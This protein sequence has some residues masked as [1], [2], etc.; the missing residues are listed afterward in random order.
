MPTSV[1]TKAQKKQSS[2]SL[3]LVEKR[4]RSPA[5]HKL[6]AAL[7]SL[8]NACF[9]VL[10]TPFSE[11]KQDTERLYWQH[12]FA[13]IA[14]P[15]SL[16]LMESKGPRHFHYHYRHR[17]D[18]ESVLQPVLEDPVEMLAQVCKEA[19][20]RCQREFAG[21][22]DITLQRSRQMFEGALNG[23]LSQYQDFKT[24]AQ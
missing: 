15:V 16:A 18:D 19:L 5:E 7:L 24:V 14:N 23:F 8:E 12:R 11:R 10:D 20:K 3:K 22:H 17:T 4:S 21:M 13:N 9:A 6:E 2:L 1:R